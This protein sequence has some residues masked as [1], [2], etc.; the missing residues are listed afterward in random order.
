[1]RG[2]AC[3]VGRGCRTAK[4][5]LASARAPERV[6]FAMPKLMMLGK[7]KGMVGDPTTPRTSEHE[8]AMLQKYCS[9][10]TAGRNEFAKQVAPLVRV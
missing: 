4:Y 6:L 10:Q 8:E 1:M 3:K 2:V 5:E 9:K 7:A